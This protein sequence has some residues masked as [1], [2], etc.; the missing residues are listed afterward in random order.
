MANNVRSRKLTAWL[1]RDPDE[2]GISKHMRRNILYFRKVAKA[3]PPWVDYDKVNEI[4]KESRRRRL[5]GENCVVDHIVPLN[6]PYVQG[7]HWHGNLQIISYE[8]NERKSN[9]YWPDMP[10]DE[11][12]DL[13]PDVV[14][15]EQYELIL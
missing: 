2:P 8:E 4:Y 9:F 15:C 14:E 6:H 11:Q 12:L 10:A 5:A 13:F 3:T 1:K 7:L